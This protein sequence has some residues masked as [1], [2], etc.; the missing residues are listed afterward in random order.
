M[1]RHEE[2]SI[3]AMEDNF[4]KALKRIEQ[5]LV[6]LETLASNNYNVVS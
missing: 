4:A 5:Q 2:D 1:I 6:S 3:A